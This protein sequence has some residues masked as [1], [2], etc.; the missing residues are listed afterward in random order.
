LTGE[1]RSAAKPIESASSGVRRFIGIN[2]ILR[3]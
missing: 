2:L 3:G 1:A